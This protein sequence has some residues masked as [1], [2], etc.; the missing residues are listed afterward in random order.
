[1]LGW[2]P[3]HPGF[4]ATPFGVSDAEIASSG[5]LGDAAGANAGSADANVHAHAIDHGADALQI[6]IPAAAPG[7][8]G[9]A[10]HVAKRRPFAA[11]LAFLCHSY[12]LLIPGN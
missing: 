2:G 10:D 7:I 4:F 12:S 8:V 5:C 1:M 6:G 11:N 9:M 3:H